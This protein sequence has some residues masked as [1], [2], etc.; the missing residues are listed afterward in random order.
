MGCS[1]YVDCELFLANRDLAQLSVAGQA[2]GGRPT[3]D[4]TLE[5][6]LLEVEL[7]PTKYGNLLFEALFP[8]GDD[9][10]AGYRQSL[11]IARHE[12]K[13]LRLR[14][15]IA[16]AAPPGLHDLHWEL[17]H[18]A[19]LQ[20]APARSQEIAFSRHLG[21]P[22][23][24]RKPVTERPRLLIVLSC[25]RNLSTYGL[26]AISREAMRKD[27][28]QALSSLENLMVWEFLKGPATIENIR[29]RLIAGNFHALHLTGHGLL[30]TERKT[31]Q[32]ALET[33]GGFVR[34]IGEELFAEIFAGQRNLR[35]ISLIACHGGATSDRDPFSG[36][37]TA[38]VQRG[39]PAVVAMRRQISLGGAACFTT[40]FYRN[41]ARSGRVD[42]AANEARLQ[43]YLAESDEPEWGIPTLY[44][45]LAE[46]RLWEPREEP[47]PE[48]G[49][50]SL[51]HFRILRRLGHG[52]M[53]EVFLAEDLKLQRKVA[54]KVMTEKLA[55]DSTARKRFLREARSAAA[56]DHPYVCTVFEVA[57]ADG[58][59]FIAME[60]IEGETLKS[61]LEKN[62]LSPQEAL[63]VV[64]E[65]AEALEE[66][67][68]Q[69][70]IHRDLKP[71]NIM[72]TTS[73]R[74]KVLDFGLAKRLEPKLRESQLETL[75]KTEMA[76]EL[77]APGTLLGTVAYMSPEQLRRQK[78]DQRS[79]IFSLGV[80]LHELLSGSHPFKRKT[81]MDMATAILQD[82]PPPI[83]TFLGNTPDLLERT[84]QKMLAKDRTARYPSI[85]EAQAH[86]TELLQTHYGT[87]PTQSATEARW[88]VSR[89]TRPSLSSP[90]AWLGIAAITAAS[91]VGKWF[92][93]P[94][95]SLPDAYVVRSAPVTPTT[96]P[97]VKSSPFDPKEA[98][99]TPIPSPAAT[100]A[101]LV[102]SLAFENLNGNP[103]LDQLEIGIAGA[104]TEAFVSSGRFRSVERAQLDKVL[105]ELELNQGSHVDPNTAQ[106]LGLL[107]GVKYIT[108][109]SFQEWQGELRLNARLLQVETGEILAAETTTGPLEQALYIPGDLARM[110]IADLP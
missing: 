52:G 89:S 48:P 109:G 100:N 11:A 33:D 12:D 36:L 18:D 90:G 9:L 39:V 101:P 40:N 38:L 97:P 1:N 4:T 32:L 44:M 2:Y 23:K 95:D 43:L 62:P 54:L 80:V 76:D 92:A 65:V 66:A 98:K 73:G 94:L 27:L 35:L 41:L 20:I 105:K 59:V 14:L 99:S 31:A 88:L 87:P 10:L 6:R 108:L 91:L 64:S 22:L 69:R 46:G 58:V 24:V 56:L 70:I 25:P 16:S 71:A 34:F 106:R 83:S 3:L 72:L 47:R 8:E 77:T 61:R 110:L 57:E 26:P 21:V 107:L 29:D 42:A 49:V 68:R 55:A 53:G 37:G 85:H 60:L 84:L 104:L 103:A 19:R 81:S 13:C 75:T 63:K 28:D 50:K 93:R 30:S 86:L 67:H 45:R 96:A 79:D 78:L 51:S 102:A 17:L 5:R 7:E 82:P 15:Q 74:A